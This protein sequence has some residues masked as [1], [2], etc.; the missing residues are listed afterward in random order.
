VLDDRAVFNTKDGKAHLV[1]Y[2]FPF[3]PNISVD[4]TIKVEED[5]EAPDDDDE[6]D[7]DVKDATDDDDDDTEDDE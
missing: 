2:H 4:A 6:D 7:D 1:P 5:V 3:F